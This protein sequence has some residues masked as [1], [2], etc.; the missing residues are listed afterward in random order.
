MEAAQDVW[1]VW[2]L[3]RA[4]VDA[5]HMSPL[6]VWEWFFLVR[7]W[8]GRV[9]FHLYNR[10]KSLYCRKIYTS[11]FSA[12]QSLCCQSSVAQIWSAEFHAW[13]E[14]FSFREAVM[15][16]I[17]NF[18]PWLPPH[19]SRHRRREAFVQ[20]LWMALG[21]R[22]PLHLALVAIVEPW[23]LSYLIES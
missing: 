7:R 20:P 18:Y 17:T 8:I 5:L 4:D 6:C 11:V 22:I 1:R 9:S 16:F 2:L 13:Y 23:G 3:S 14:V 19:P 15:F 10:C 21:S 12:S